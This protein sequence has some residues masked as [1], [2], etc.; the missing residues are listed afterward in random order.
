[1]LATMLE[2][3]VIPE[4]GGNLL[5]QVVTDF[6]TGGKCR[7]APHHRSKLVKGVYMNVLFSP[8]MFLI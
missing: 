5:L 3:A 8:K 4:E 6:L 1:M 7:L 2:G